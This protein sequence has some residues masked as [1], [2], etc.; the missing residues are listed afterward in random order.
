M[1][2]FCSQADLHSPN[3]SRSGFVRINSGNDLGYQAIT[4]AISRFETRAGEGTRTPDQLITNQL[5][6]QLSYTGNYFQADS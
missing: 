2:T 1:R 5:L 3:P 6:Y 4:D